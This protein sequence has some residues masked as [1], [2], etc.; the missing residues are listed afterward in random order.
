MSGSSNRENY[1]NFK[2]SR[3]YKGDFWSVYKKE[4]LNAISKNISPVDE[5]SNYTILPQI[6]ETVIKNFNDINSNNKGLK[7][8]SHKNEKLDKNNASEIMKKKKNGMSISNRELLNGKN[9]ISKNL[10]NNSITDSD[11]TLKDRKLLINE[12]NYRNP[13][14]FKRKEENPNE[15]ID[16]N[17]NTT[18]EN[19]FTKDDDKKKPYESNSHKEKQITNYDDIKISEKDL[20][21]SNDALNIEEGEEETQHLIEFMSNLDY[22]KYVRDLHIR[23]ALHLIKNKIEKENELEIRQKDF[24]DY[25]NETI[26]KS[27]ISV[28]DNINKADFKQ[29][30]FNEKCISNRFVPEKDWDNSV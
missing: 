21:D 26:D 8:L 27:I 10:S 16:S 24:S 22:S 13:N 11:I 12:N 23:E 3:I 20:L 6:G 9:V 25:S 19:Y 5:K 2:N 15:L 17:F 28:Q 7:T 1:K 4:D 14:F 29:D 18:L 30:S